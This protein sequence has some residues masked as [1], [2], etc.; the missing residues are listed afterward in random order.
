MKLNR[1]YCK[2]IKSRL[3]ENP[4][5]IWKPTAV[6]FYTELSNRCNYRLCDETPKI[7]WKSTL[8]VHRTSSCLFISWPTSVVELLLSLFCGRLNWFIFRLIDVYI[9]RPCAAGLVRTGIGLVRASSG[10]ALAF[11]RNNLCNIHLR[12]LL[13]NWMSWTNKLMLEY[14][15]TA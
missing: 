14:L 4:P 10:Y 3:V 6:L 1:C 5:I 7:R 9:E 2:P 8:Y 12:Q 15:W 13:L 11:G